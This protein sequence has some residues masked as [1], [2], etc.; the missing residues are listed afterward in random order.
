[1]YIYTHIYAYILKQTNRER[2]NKEK[3]KVRREK[4]K[5]KENK[6]KVTVQRTKGEK[7]EEKKSEAE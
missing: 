4:D 2:E 3:G 1:M 6:K 5:K 7:K